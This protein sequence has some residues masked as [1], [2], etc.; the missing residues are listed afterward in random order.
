MCP[1]VLVSRGTEVT[2]FQDSWVGKIPS[3]QS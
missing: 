2:G 1:A 3:A